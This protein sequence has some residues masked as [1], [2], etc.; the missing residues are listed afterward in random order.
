MDQLHYGFEHQHKLFSY[1]ATTS[2]LL[3]LAGRMS[4]LHNNQ[5]NAVVDSG[6]QKKEATG[7]KRRASPPE[8]KRSFKKKLKREDEPTMDVSIIEASPAITAVK[9][10]FFLAFYA[11]ALPSIASI[12]QLVATKARPDVMRALVQQKMPS[13][14]PMRKTLREDSTIL[15]TSQRCSFCR[16]F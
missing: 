1:I 12:H 11:I 16:I 6:A 9:L 13:E 8:K 2:Q 15:E 3:R 5:D 4:D 14:R 7:K 10:F